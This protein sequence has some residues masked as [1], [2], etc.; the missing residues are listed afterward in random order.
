MGKGIASTFN[1]K[2]NTDGREK[3][4]SRPRGKHNYKQGQPVRMYFQEENIGKA[5]KYLNMEHK[6]SQSPV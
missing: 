6:V 3:S 5:N 1:T 4:L 2:A